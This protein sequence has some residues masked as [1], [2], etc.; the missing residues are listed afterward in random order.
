MSECELKKRRGLRAREEE[1]RGV[2]SKRDDQVLR[3]NESSS[4]SRAKL[5]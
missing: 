4:W 5:Y 1:A 3:F 2:H